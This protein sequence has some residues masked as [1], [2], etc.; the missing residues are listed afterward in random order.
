MRMTKPKDKIIDWIAIVIATT[1]IVGFLLA[2][3][4]SQPKMVLAVIVV[5]AFVWSVHRILDMLNRK[6]RGY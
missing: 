4:I 5:A 2:W 3:A 6:H 1:I